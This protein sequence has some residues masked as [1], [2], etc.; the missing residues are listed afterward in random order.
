MVLKI[1]VIILGSALFFFL[2]HRI[3]SKILPAPAEPIV[4]YLLD[5]KLRHWLQ[6]PGK[7]I[8]RS[9]IKQGMT[10]MELGCGNG[11]Y[12]HLLTR[13]V[14]DEGRVLAIDI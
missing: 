4:G 7:V 9:G 12:T 2:I 13:V 5:S 1:I 10:I 8:K 14:G 3:T 11:A 6:P